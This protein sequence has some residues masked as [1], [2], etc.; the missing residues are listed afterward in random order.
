MRKFEHLAPAPAVPQGFDAE[1]HG[2]APIVKV[3]EGK[4]RIDI[5][6]T[7]P[8]YYISDDTYEVKGKKVEFKQLNIA[9]AGFLAESGRPLLPSFGR[10]VQ[11]PFGSDFKVSV[12]EGKAVQADDILVLPSQSLVTDSPE[13]EHVFEYDEAFYAKD[14]FYPGETVEVKG[15]FEIDG[16]NSLLI[17]V[18]PLQYNPAKRKLRGFGTVT[19]TIELVSKK[20]EVAAD[21]AI[22]PRQDREAFGNLFLNPRRGIDERVDIQDVDPPTIPIRRGPE[23]LIIYHNAFKKAAEKLAQW[24]TM[25]GIA[26]K[27]VSVGDVGTTVEDIKTYIRN[28]R[29][30]RLSRLRYVLLFGD[31]DMIPSEEG[32]AGSPGPQSGNITDYYYSTPKDPQNDTSDLV[33]PWLATGRIPVRTADE[34]TAVVDQIISYEKN[35]P[36]EP[37]YYERMVFGAYFQDYEWGGQP[38]GKASRAY[39]KTMEDIRK[40]MLTLGF[41][42]VRV[43]VAQTPNVQEYIDGT[44]VP[45]EVKDAIV[46]GGIATDMLISATAEGQ[47]IA[48]H[49]D[50]GSPDGWYEPA[51]LKSHLDAL[52]S[53]QPT[54]FYSLNCQTGRFDLAAPTESFA[55][56]MLRM[57]AGAP[58][59]IAAT[60]NSNTWLNNDLMKS[61]FDG[62]WSGVLPTFPGS[63]GSYSVK[64]NRLGDLLNYGK[65][66]LPVGQSGGASQVKDHFEIYHVVGDPTLEIWKHEPLRVTVSA[67]LERLAL[68]I[69]LSGCPA[70]SVITIWFGKR[71]LKRIEPHSTEVTVALTEEPVTVLPQPPGQERLMV[72]FWAPG[73]RFCRVYPRLS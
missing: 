71:M 43:Y 9:G 46:D 62:M 60:R 50:H 22:D 48:G 65:A 52:T 53:E 11:I 32:Q 17:H 66:Y 63:S 28:M 36:C 15:P 34:A 37:G 57:K 55:E 12:K 39:M 68:K 20:G 30:P 73:H 3:K 5:T 19:V 35:P 13:E 61:L 10:Y 27:V 25:R 26:T 44:P 70:G 14:E 69:R 67:R 45:Q 58:S 8:G 6:Y 42:V 56:K 38:D 40:H 54:M 18:R 4:Q 72:C 41:D 51:F 31:V 24:K 1:I 49:R 64:Y 33:L 21:H 23:F 2:E 7:F 59:L 47:L 16:Y 29:K